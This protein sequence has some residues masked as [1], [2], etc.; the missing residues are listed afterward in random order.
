M[1]RTLA[2]LLLL[3]GSL[4]VC[5]PAWAQDAT[6]SPPDNHYFVSQGSWGQKY[7]DQWALQRIGFDTSPQ[8]A[9]RL[10]KRNAQPVVVALIDTGLDWNHRNIDWESIWKNPKEV[11]DNSVDDDKNGYVDDVV[12]FDFVERDNKPWDYDG[13]GTFIAGI[14]AGSWKDKD[15]M[16]GINPFA[17]L[18]ILKAVNNFGHTRASYLAEAIAY[19]AD[20]G[21]RVINLSV[22]DKEVTKVE[23][24]AIDY[25]YS[26]GVVI[27][28]A[29]G[30]EGVEIS[31]YGIASSDKVL[32]VA[33]TGFDDERVVFSNW[34]K[35]AVAAPGLDVLSLRARRTDV[36]LG[37]EGVKYTAGAAYVG[38][39]KRHYRA[40][41]TSFS[42]PMVSGLASLMIANNPSLTN[43]QVMN[44]IKSTARDVGTPG[45]DQYTGYG[46]IDARAALK[47]PKDYF[48]F[49]G[50]NRVE[51][52]QKS[53][54][55][56]VRVHGTADANAFKSARLEIGQGDAP[57]SWTPVGAAQKAAG[58][59]AVLGDIPA[60]AF[61]GA[62]KWE[63]RVVVSHADGSTREARFKLSLG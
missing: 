29:A 58:P 8:S 43:R 38:D 10:V 53:G 23:Q 26:K 25:A 2:S 12:G 62:N 17:R 41:G 55:Q 15:G 52:V 20:N 22:G 19:A 14:L 56:T 4:G 32:A 35:I 3:C 27:V 33:S 18:M 50:I 21:A 40:S 24:A 57:T 42:A 30:N 5:G 16:A 1:T 49:A 11:P 46:I 44:I 60:T 37:I 54:N 34:G 28:V 7:A 6:L 47:A 39:D 31:N 48:L 61:R 51:V 9:W 63:I 45:V 36:M 13:H 59:D